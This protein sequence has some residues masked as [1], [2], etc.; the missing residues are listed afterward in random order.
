M[1]TLDD[2]E[3]MTDLTRKEI[4]AVAE[5]EHLGE[6]SAALLGDYLMH[7]HHGPQQVA[8]MIAEDVRDALRRDDLGHAKELFATL[9]HFM[10][11]HPE[12]ARGA[13]R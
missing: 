9:R 4:E 6:G 5:H 12:A 13:A 8:Q 10:A 7:L 11:E 2:I 3:D 1:I